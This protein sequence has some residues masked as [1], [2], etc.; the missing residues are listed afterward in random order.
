M[1]EGGLKPQGSCLLLGVPS[2]FKIHYPASCE[3]FTSK[4][5][6]QRNTGRAHRPGISIL[7][8][9]AELSNK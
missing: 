2:V 1:E 3:L 4:N 9:F 6:T 5:V 8:R 7:R